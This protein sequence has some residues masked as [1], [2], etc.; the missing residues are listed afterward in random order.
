LNK[1][2]LPGVLLATVMI[3]GIF[4]FMPVQDATTIHNVL[5]SQDQIL[6]FTYVVGGDDA[7]DSDIPLTPFVENGYTGEV[8]I[9]VVT[10][11]SGQDTSTEFDCGWDFDIEAITD[12]SDDG[13][14]NTTLASVNPSASSDSDSDTFDAGDGVDQLFLTGDDDSSEQDLCSVAVTIFLDGTNT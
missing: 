11:P 8:T 7:F 4:A 1:L 9:N 6:Y 12:D 13:S 2:V 10:L 14:P 3:A 5:R